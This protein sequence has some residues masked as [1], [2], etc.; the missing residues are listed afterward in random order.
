MRGSVESGFIVGIALLFTLVF[1]I[2]MANI[3]V[4]AKPLILN[5]TTAS[6]AKVIAA[7]GDTFYLTG[8]DSLLV[9]F[10]F[11]SVVGV[12]VSA[13]YES[14]DPNT[15]PI[16]ILFLIPLILITFPLSDFAYHFIASQPA[17]VADHFSGTLYI[18]AW[19]PVFTT[20]ITLGYLIFVVRKNN[21][22]PHGNNIISG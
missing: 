14:A 19:L 9:F 6:G 20:V 13:Y 7:L 17:A 15:L 5:S 12:F 21:L 22:M 3:W 8:T 16:G 4:Q 18:L 11:I 1:F 2:V 10:Y